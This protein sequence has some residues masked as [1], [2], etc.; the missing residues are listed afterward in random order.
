MGLMK[1]NKILKKYKQLNKDHVEGWK[2]AVKRINDGKQT[3]EQESYN[4]QLEGNRLFESLMK[5]LEGHE[6]FPKKQSLKPINPKK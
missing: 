3:Y 5:E 4:Y 6:I 1:I 2:R